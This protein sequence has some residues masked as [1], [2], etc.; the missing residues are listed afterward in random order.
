MPAFLNALLA[1]APQN[2][3]TLE[4]IASVIGLAAGCS[5]TKQSLSQRLSRAIGQF[6]SQ[7]IT[8]LFGQLCHGP[9]TSHL[10]DGFSR[11]LLQD[12]TCQAL[13]KHL[14][15]VF[16][17]AGNQYCPNHATLKIQWICDIKNSSVEHVSLS[18]FTRNDQ[19]AAADI[20][21]VA[22]PG[23]LVLRDL[24]HLTGPVLAQFVSAGIFFLSRYRHDTTLYDPTHGKP[25]DLKA[26]LKRSGH[27]DRVVLLGP[28][29][30]QMRLV[31]LP[32]PQEIANLRRHKAKTTAAQHTH[33]SAPGRQH[34]FLMGW[35]LFLTNV[36][37]AVWSANILRVVYSLRWRIEI[38]FKTWKSHLGL[39][40]FNCS[41]V[42]L[43][44]LS[45]LTRLLFCALVCQVCDLMELRCPAGQHVS[46]LRVG[47]IL[48]QCAC[49]FCATV[50]GISVSQWLEFNFKRRAFYE[51]RSDRRNYYE[52]LAHPDSA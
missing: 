49:W 10:L 6:L 46:L 50:L 30:V 51:R 1:L 43:L 11:V 20:L 22:R 32:V 31:A 8:S 45:V 47:K 41:T 5:Y 13:P 39:R 34:L 16:P 35:N 42:A 29:R 44:E 40:H 14:A 15:S 9:T 18:G 28:Q 4:H 24:G 37:A 33:R 21:Q 36:P 23:D 25:L 17:G 2:H 48:S 52:F 19:T 12:S 26:L 7:V 3:L 27:L 38:I